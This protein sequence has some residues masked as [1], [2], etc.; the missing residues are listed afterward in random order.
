MRLVTINA[1][2]SGCV[3]LAAEKGSE[4]VILIAYLPVSIEEIRFVRNTES[5]MVK[6]IFP[7]NKLAR[8]FPAP[9]MTRPASMKHLLAPKPMDPRT[10]PL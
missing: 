2:D 5:I 1:A 3:H 9:R 8:E 6:V 4:L 7:G 10:A